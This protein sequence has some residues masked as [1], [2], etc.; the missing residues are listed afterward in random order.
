MRILVASNRSCLHGNGF[1]AKNH[2]K[3]PSAGLI[4]PGRTG[5]TWLRKV[6]GRFLWTR[7]SAR[8]LHD[9][10]VRQVRDN[11]TSRKQTHSASWFPRCKKRL[12]GVR[13]GV[14]RLFFDCW[15]SGENPRNPRVFRDFALVAQWIE[16]RFPNL[17]TPTIADCEKRKKTPCFPVSNALLYPAPQ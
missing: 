5:P 16:H 7:V 3:R 1:P 11:G 9:V 10:P 6:L 2:R 12:S 4:R 17:P 15:I 8:L 14:C 13:K